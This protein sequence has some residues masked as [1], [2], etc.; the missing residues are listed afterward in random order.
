MLEKQ[1][2]NTKTI[3]TLINKTGLYDI[4]GGDSCEDVSCKC[5]KPS[6]NKGVGSV[7][8]PRGNLHRQ[9]KR[10]LMLRDR[11]R[12][13]FDTVRYYVKQDLSFSDGKILKS[14]QNIDSSKNKMKRRD[15]GDKISGSTVR[16]Y[17]LV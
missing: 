14:G 8:S 3:K 17:I 15:S 2:F 6:D 7:T 12:L 11:I 16:L 4:V 5:D 10:C 1:S 13:I 9:Y